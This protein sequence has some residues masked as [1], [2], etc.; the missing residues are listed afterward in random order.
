M[1]VAQVG[2]TMNDAWFPSEQC[3]GQD[4]QRGILRT[5]D[6]NRPGERVAAVDENLVHTWQKGIVSHLNNRFSNKCRG[7]FFPPRPKEALR[8][9]RVRFPRPASRPGEVA[10][11][12]A[13]SIR[14]LIR[15][16]APRRRGRPPDRVKLHVTEYVDLAWR[17]RED[18]QRS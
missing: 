13:Q 4:R 5:A 6:L 15:H 16:R 1:R 2:H 9:G 7:N 10:E 14:A 17:C 11:P 8:S 18:S 12:L 3:R